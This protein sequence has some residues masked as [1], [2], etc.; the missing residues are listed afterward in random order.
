MKVTLL[1]PFGGGGEGTY[2]EELLAHPPKNVSY[3]H[4]PDSSP[5]PLK[6]VGS[7]FSFSRRKLLYR[8]AT[9][10]MLRVKEETDLV[11]VHAV[12]NKI[13]KRPEVPI[14]MSASS[15]SYIFL[16]DYLGW[17]EEKIQSRYRLGK[18]FYKLFNINDRLLNLDN[19]KHL[20]VWSNFA[21]KIYLRF[22][23][24]EEKISVVYPGMPVRQSKRTE[25]DDEVKFLFIGK[26]LTRKGAFLVKKSFEKLVEEYDNIKLTVV[27]S[28]T[29]KLADS[30]N[31]NCIR[32]MQREALF[33]KVFP[34]HD[35]FL[36]PVYNEGFGIT[37]EE[38]MS[39]G[40]PVISTNIN[41][42]P[43]LVENEKTGFLIERG[44]SKELTEKMRILIDDEELRRK[45]RKN[46]IERF[47]NKFWYERTN[48]ALY[49]VYKNAV[50]SI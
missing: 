10:K 25:P 36:F 30:R 15:S 37:I 50:Q 31:I 38:A 49:N 7:A 17:S 26:K 29:E 35:V 33:N 13:F 40:M 8:D 18:I 39:F 5:F 46:T 27:T 11:H 43:E 2:I 21:K 32:S 6:V 20:I 22:G 47:K 23:I 44:N 16:K 14:I 9:I 34:I 48:E 28:Q 41:A 19:V 45:M 12:A 3:T 4:Y 42:I 1:S 24:P